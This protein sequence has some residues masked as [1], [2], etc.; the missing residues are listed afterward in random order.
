MLAMA[1][2][3]ETVELSADEERKVAAVRDAV[4]GVVKVG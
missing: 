1:R 2:W 3:Y 4:A